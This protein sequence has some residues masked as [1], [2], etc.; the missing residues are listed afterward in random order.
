M[1]HD[2]ASVAV[3][4]AP[5]GF[6]RTLRTSKA[7]VLF[8]L[9]AVA[10]IFVADDVYHLIWFSKTL[11]LFALGAI[12]L[13]ARGMSW[14]DIGFRFGRGVWAMVIIGLIGGGLIEMQELFFTQ[15]LMIAITDQPPDLSD[16]RDVRGNWNMVLVGLPLIWVLAAFGEEWVYRGWLT[17]RLADLFGR[18][19]TGW[20]IAVVIGNAAFGL[21]HLYQGPTGVVEAAVDGLLF[22]LLY[23]I[24]GRNLIAPMVAH[25]VQDSI[26]LVLGF[27]GTYPIPF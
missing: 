27:T 23:F 16:F 5:S 7:L 11:Y 19:W 15:P 18:K 12:S 3:E 1:T 9:A 14:G 26:D 8:E 17:N 6:R 10:A 13:M 2:M 25:G 21:A 22:A 20:L 24:T 4:S